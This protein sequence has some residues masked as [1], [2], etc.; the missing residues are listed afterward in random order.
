MYS[1]F[2]RRCVANASWSTLLSCSFVERLEA[3]KES[4]G[5]E[6]PLV[7]RKKRKVERK[8]LPLLATGDVFSTSAICPKGFSVFSH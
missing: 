8:L 3:T 2:S 5:D 6:F 1:Q 7:K 4:E